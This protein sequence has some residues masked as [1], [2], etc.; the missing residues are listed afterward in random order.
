MIEF[1]VTVEGEDPKVGHWVCWVDA[2]SERLLLVNEDKTFRWVAQSDCRFARWQTPDQPRLVLA[3]Q[4]QQIQ[5][6]P[7]LSRLLQN[8]RMRPNRDR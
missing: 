4:P 8:P 1:V 5:V 6:P 7:D 3:V 2:A